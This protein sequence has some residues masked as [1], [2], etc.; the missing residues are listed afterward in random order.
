M[1]V[2]IYQTAHS[3]YITII[4][5]IVHNLT[6]DFIVLEVPQEHTKTVNVMHKYHGDI[7]LLSPALVFIVCST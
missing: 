1:L 4:I 2:P 5:K 7:A 6:R 3:P